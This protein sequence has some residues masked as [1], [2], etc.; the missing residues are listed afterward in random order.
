[1]EELLQPFLVVLDWL[2]TYQITLGGHSFTFF[3]VFIIVALTNIVI[4]FLW[5][6]FER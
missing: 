5:W 2:K 3:N 6:L 4:G 1:M